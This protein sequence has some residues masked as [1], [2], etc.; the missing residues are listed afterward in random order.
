MQAQYHFEEWVERY[1]GPDSLWDL[2]SE[3][4]ADGNIY[5]AGISA[6]NRGG[7]TY[8]D[9]T[10]LKYNTN[11]V[12]QWVQTFDGA[13]NKS[14]AAL[15][16]ALDED[17]NVYVTG[18]SVNEGSTF[19]D[20]YT[21]ISYTTNGDMQWIQHYNGP[22]SGSDRA[23]DLALDPEGNVYV[24]GY[25]FGGSTGYDFATVKYSL[26][27]PS[28][29][30][31]PFDFVG[32]MHNLG[33][34]YIA[35]SDERSTIL[36]TL[37][38][39]GDRYALDIE[40]ARMTSEFICQHSDKIRA[41]TR[42]AFRQLD[43]C[44]NSE[45]CV[46]SEEAFNYLLEIGDIIKNSNQ[47]ETSE[48]LIHDIIAL[49]AEVMNSN[50]SLQDQTVILSAGSVGRHSHSFLMSAT[51]AP[52][53]LAGVS[54]IN[55]MACAGYIDGEVANEADIAGAI[56]G[57]FVGLCTGPGAIVLGAAGCI[58]SSIGNVVAQLL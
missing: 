11:G 7:N 56:G 45:Q 26:L 9:L 49:E 46:V 2:A 4:D 31:N 3:I 58:G 27:D 39:S 50:M 57:A 52:C 33:M 17:E 8:T 24:T 32:R 29:P 21:T 48:D 6:A 54:I 28:N 34:E 35:G 30:D 38:E 44:L 43:T 42:Q 12:L 40:I 15:A 16:L 18:Y 1:N 13:L 37:A 14:D 25:S 5:V 10:I 47:N 36:M 51:S 55:L 23:N 20:D 19:N 41:E 53:A 22:G